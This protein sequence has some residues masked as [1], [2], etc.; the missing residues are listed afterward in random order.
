MRQ[1]NNQKNSTMG[2]EVFKQKEIKG[3]IIIQAKFIR[4]TKDSYYLDC[5]GDPVWFPK[6]QVNFSQEKEELDCPKWL[7][8]EKFPNE[9]F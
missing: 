3:G 5:E 4:E 1:T 7:L 6:S 9:K 2:K 8:E